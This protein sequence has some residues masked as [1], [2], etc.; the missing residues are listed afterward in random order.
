[1]DWNGHSSPQDVGGNYGFFRQ[2]GGL[3]GTWRLHVR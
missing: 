2:H 1:M 3:E